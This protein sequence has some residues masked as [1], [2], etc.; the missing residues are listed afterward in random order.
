[1]KTIHKKHT[2]EIADSGTTGHFLEIDLPCDSKKCITNDGIILT[3]TD[4]NT[5]DL[6]QTAL[7]KLK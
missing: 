1:M 4:G 5:M 2:D 6:S 7:L 3:L